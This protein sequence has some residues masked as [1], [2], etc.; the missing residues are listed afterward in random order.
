MER[1]IRMINIINHN[2]PL[3]SEDCERITFVHCED[4]REPKADHGV[5][6]YMSSDSESTIGHLH[7]LDIAIRK[8]IVSEYANVYGGGVLDCHSLDE[9]RSSYALE[10]TNKR[11]V[12]V[13]IDR[14]ERKRE[15]LER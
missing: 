12:D 5:F 2:A 1:Q 13:F 14:L 9:K 15:K 4:T 10:S 6:I 8:G 11:S 7:L 3:F